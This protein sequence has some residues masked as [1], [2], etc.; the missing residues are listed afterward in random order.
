MTKKKV[1][2][3]CTAN[4]ARSQMAEALVNHDL[5]GHFQAFSAGTAPAS[6]H[7][8]ALR[9][10]A[11]IG[12]DHTRARSKSLEEF[13]NEAFDYVITLCGRANE[14]CPVFFGDVE[15]SHLGFDDPAAASGMEDEVLA[16]FRRVRD[17]IR[18]TVERYLRGKEGLFPA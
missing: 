4:S 8:A 9:V 17:E 15:R 6:P 3:L 13:E 14:T 12:I 10:L 2:F 7:P 11:E 1:L 18:E 5:G 16:A